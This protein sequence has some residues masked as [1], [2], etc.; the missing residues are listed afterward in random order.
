MIAVDF[1]TDFS[2]NTIAEPNTSV[3]ELLGELETHRT[4]IALTTSRRGLKNQVNSESIVET[5]EET[6]Q[7]DRLLRW[8][9]WIHAATW[10]GERIWM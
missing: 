9:P 7:H 4:T 1:V 3:D 6:A 5:L 10:D 8:G 2:P